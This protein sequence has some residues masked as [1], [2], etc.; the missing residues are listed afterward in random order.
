MDTKDIL[1]MMEMEAEF[2][3]LIKRGLEILGSYGPDLRELAR[4]IILGTV[5][6]KME[7]IQ[8][9]EAAGFTREDAMFLVMDEWFAIARYAKTAGKK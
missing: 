1:E 9:Y 4:G 8:K 7:A 6:L 3:P 2:R 5:D